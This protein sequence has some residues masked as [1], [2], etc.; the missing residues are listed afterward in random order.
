MKWGLRGE[1]CI[2]VSERFELALGMSVYGLV[3]LSAKD[4]VQRLWDSSF[5]SRLIQQNYTNECIAD[6]EEC[7]L[8]PFRSP[9]RPAL[10]LPKTA[11]RLS[12]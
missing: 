11:L 7:L 2:E 6:T 9:A 12:G 5:L 10:H 1:R 8:Y 3:P 4:G